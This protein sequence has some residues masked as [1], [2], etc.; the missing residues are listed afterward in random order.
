MSPHFEHS[1]FIERL[2]DAMQQRMITGKSL[3]EAAGISKQAVS[4]YL[5]SGRQPT[6]S[7]L[8]DWGQEFGLNIDWLVLGRGDMLTST[9]PTPDMVDEQD[10]VLRRLQTVEAMMLR[11]GAS[12]EE[13]RDAL[14]MALR[15]LSAAGADDEVSEKPEAAVS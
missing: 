11:H 12:P 14:R 8:A 3:A 10:P 4:G 1:L 5:N 2:K 13:V 7:V 15:T 6:A 9:P